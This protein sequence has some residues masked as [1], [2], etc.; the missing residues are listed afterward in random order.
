MFSIKV[1]R[2]ISKPIDIVFAKLADHA[3]YKQFKGVDDSSLLEEGEND[4]NGLGAIREIVAAGGTLHEKIVAYEPPTL[5]SYK[6]VYSKP[7]PYQHELGQIKLL[8][9]DENTTAVEWLSKGRISVP[10]LGPWYFDKQLQKNGARAF[11]SIL[12]SIDLA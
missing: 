11:G 2:K 6:I 7:L 8:A 9:L 3:N 10:L 4:K 12:K 1:E 5:L